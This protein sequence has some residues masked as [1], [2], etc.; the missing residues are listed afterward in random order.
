MNLIEQFCF[1]AGFNIPNETEDIYYNTAEKETKDTD[2]TR[3]YT[4]GG[5]LIAVSPSMGDNCERKT[6][7]TPLGFEILK[8]R[9]LDLFNANL[10]SIDL[11][12]GD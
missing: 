2:V 11:I 12:K 8:A 10:K 5:R 7:F 9:A 6:K 1:Q 3:Y 4:I